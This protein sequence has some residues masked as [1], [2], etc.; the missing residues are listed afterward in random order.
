MNTSDVQAINDTL[1]AVQHDVARLRHCEDAEAQRAVTPLT[2]HV[3]DLTQLLAAHA[4]ELGERAADRITMEARIPSG[5]RTRQK[6]RPWSHT[7]V[8]AVRTGAMNGDTDAAIAERL[9]RPEAMVTLK[10]RGLGLTTPRRIEGDAFTAPAPASPRPVPE[11]S[12][13]TA[14]TPDEMRI[15]REMLANRATYAAVGVRLGR[16]TGAVRRW[17]NTNRVKNTAPIAPR[18]VE[19]RFV[20]AA[21]GQLAALPDRRP[22]SPD[23]QRALVRLMRGGGS[24][25]EA[26]K[27]LGRGVLECKRQWLGLQRTGVAMFDSDAARGVMT[28]GD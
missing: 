3:R 10:R 20:P 16:T 27:R 7:E 18:C 25:S 14:W 19:R 15:A 5:R 13:Y 1:A 4:P 23:D 28:G 8:E 22:W 17:A 21:V 9:S 12:P 2:T 26:A 24:L 6:T 11:R